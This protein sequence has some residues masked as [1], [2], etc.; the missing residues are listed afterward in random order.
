[1]SNSAPQFEFTSPGKWGSQGHCYCSYEF[2]ILVKADTVPSILFLRLRRVIIIGLTDFSPP[3]PH[4]RES[5]IPELW[6]DVFL[7][8]M[9]MYYNECMPQRHSSSIALFCRS[10]FS[11]EGQ[12]HVKGKSPSKCLVNIWKWE[13]NSA[14][15]SCHLTSNTHLKKTQF[16]PHKPSLAP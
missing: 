15:L 13:T 9:E 14:V 5:I 4:I 8:Y 10:H 11:H 12:P 2:S 6:L 1:M 7:L 3:L 16:L